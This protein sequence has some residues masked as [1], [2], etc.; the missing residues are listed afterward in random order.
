MVRDCQKNVVALLLCLMCG[1]APQCTAAQLSAQEPAPSSAQTAAARSVGTVKAISGKS[2]TLTT[3]AGSDISVSLQDGARLLRVEPGEKDLKNAVPLELSDVEPGDRVLVRGKMSDDGKSLLA[4]SLIAMKKIDIA[5]KQSRER[6]EWQ[7]RGVGGLVSAVDL[8]S[9]TITITTT[10]LGT[11]KNIAVHVSKDTQLRRYSPNSIKFDEAKAAPI[12]EIKPGD[13]LRAR[14]NRSADGSELTAD[15]VVSGSFR[16]IAGTIASVD[17]AAG[18]ITVTDLATKKPVAVK[19]TGE[20]QLRKLPPAMAQRIAARL[21]GNSAD[22]P[23]AAASQRTGESAPT[24]GA[25]STRAN[26]RPDSGQS[27]QAG[28]GSSDLQQAL[29]RMPPATLA[30]LN[31]GD[32][33]MIVATT[34]TQDAGV[35]AITLLAGVEPILE[36]SPKGGQSILSPWSLGAPGEAA[37]P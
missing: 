25:G 8:S 27:G 35:T 28:Q 29:S 17:S 6:T 26:G 32:A 30:E 24:N 14:G 23:P 1:L 3:D 37:T 20:S 9:D 5:Q 34:G 22:T 11:S 4:A 33:V 19:V 15:E 10:A 36:A 18:T 21:K 2:L 16:N 12:S 13:Q 31:K 7:K